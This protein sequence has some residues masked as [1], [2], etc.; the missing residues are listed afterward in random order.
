MIKITHKLLL[1]LTVNTAMTSFSVLPMQSAIGQHPNHLIAEFI[2]ILVAE[3]DSP[4]CKKRGRDIDIGGSRA[5]E[6]E[7]LWECLERERPL[8]GSRADHLWNELRRQQ[9]P[10]GLR[11]DE[12]ELSTCA[13]VPGKLIDSDTG[14]ETTIEVWNTRPLFLWRG[15]WARLEVRHLDSGELMWRQTLTP[16]QQD[17]VYGDYGKPLLPGET[18][19]W[20]LIPEQLP[21]DT[22]LPKISFQIVGGKERDRITDELKKLTAESADTLTLARVHYF[23]DQ[24]LWADALHEIYS[25]P[26]QFSGLIEQ[27]EAHDFCG[28]ASASP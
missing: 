7:T 18:Y 20:Q 12:N 16:T 4:D 2:E 17:L 14:E 9:V 28:N 21:E 10:G 24:G 19:Y 15:T 11:G 27:I 25:H 26:D 1:L 5:R 13:I 23:I 6:C 22:V 8:G 3:C